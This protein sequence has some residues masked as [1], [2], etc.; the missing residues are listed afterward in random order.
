[1]AKRL[2]PFDIIH[3]LEDVPEKMVESRLS[4]SI[5]HLPIEPH[6]LREAY[7][8][9]ERRSKN[10]IAE[11]FTEFGITTP[12]EKYVKIQNNDL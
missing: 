10:I 6:I 12:K 8:E 7:F 5:R 11:V 1:M 3:Q 4:I 2:S 9:I